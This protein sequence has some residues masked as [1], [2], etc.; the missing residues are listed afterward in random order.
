M[1][2]THVLLILIL[3]SVLAA[4]LDAQTQIGG[5]TCSSST[6]TGNYAISL[7]GRQ[8]SASGNVTNLFQSSGSVNFDGLSN[9][10]ISVTAFTLASAG[11]SFAAS[12]GTPLAWSGTYS[13]QS[14]CIG[15]VTITSGGSATFNVVSYDNGVDFLLTGNDATYAYTGSG[16]TQPTAACSTSAL[17]GL[18]SFGGTGYETSGSGVIGSGDVAGTL[19]FDGQGNLTVN[20]LV[21][22]LGNSS[23]QGPYSVSSNC[24]GKATL[25]ASNGRNTFSMIFS[26]SS[27]NAVAST[28][29]F[30]T[31][32]FDFS[33]TG[34]PESV[35]VS[36]SSHAISGQPTT[37]SAAYRGAGDKSA[38]NALATLW[39]AA[40]DGRAR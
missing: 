10:T 6:F 37:A 38:G 26:V 18:Y 35:F 21:A 36:G 13:M 4:S 20:V 23:S 30:A 22:G 14:N 7:T 40:G 28:D 12:A 32:A 11:T 1:K 24:L 9:V 29:F 3:S 15:L 25:A 34:A 31:F 39:S 19:Q 17:A 27:G 8:V 2:R 16:N 33:N 5:G